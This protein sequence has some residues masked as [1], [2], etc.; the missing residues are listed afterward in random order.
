MPEFDVVFILLPTEEDF[1]AADKG[2]KINQTTIEV[3]DLDLCF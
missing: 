1:L 2:G 3:F